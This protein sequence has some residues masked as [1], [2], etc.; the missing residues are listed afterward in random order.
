MEEERVKRSDDKLMSRYFKLVFGLF[1]CAVGIVINI[2]ANLGYAPWE[3]FHEGISNIVG[4]KIG[5][6]NIIVGFIILMI[7]ISQGVIPGVGTIANMILIGS[8][9]NLIMDMNYLPVFS[10]LYIRL[11]SLLVGLTIQS[12]GTYLY[13]SAGFGTG[14]RDS[15]MIMIH[16]KTG[17]PIGFI[18]NSIEVTVLISG[19]LLGGPVGIGTVILSLGIGNI[20]QIVFNLFKFDTKDVNHR[21]FKDEA[22]FIQ[23]FFNNDI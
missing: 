21:D 22:E 19:Y 16:K 1:L 10:N 6:I 8:F 4:M 23:G 3:V 20:L 15:I 7:G 13:I 14:P 11:F 12:V 18:R 5:T 2:N 17:R 9:M